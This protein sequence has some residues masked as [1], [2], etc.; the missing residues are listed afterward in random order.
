[1]IRPFARLA[2][3]ALSAVALG[4]A[5]ARAAAVQ[6]YMYSTSGS[7]AG[8]P[9]SGYGYPIS[10]STQGD[11]MLTTP[12]TFVLGTITTSPLPTGA[13]L[14]F[15]DTPFTIDLG[16][17]AVPTGSSYYY[18]YPYG[19][20]GFNPAYTYQISGVLNGALKD[21]ISTLFPT[22]TSVTGV[23]STPPFD[24]ADLKFNLQGIA[25]P[26]GTTYGTTT[27][28]AS[29]AV[30]GNPLPSPAP[31]PTS[32]AIFAAA[33]AGFAWNRRRGRT[34]RSLSSPPARA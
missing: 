19:Y 26:V 10:L 18:G 24:P 34:K 25:A 22:I 20:Y 8:T 7:I 1:M 6:S 33:L 32:V 30:A 29:V 27:L 28:T 12:G 17:G 11:A 2:A 3:V 16:V 9:G 15:D 23:G 4:A 13:T 31:E 21:G 5:D 14:T